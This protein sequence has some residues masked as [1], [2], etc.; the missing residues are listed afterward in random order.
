MIVV[1]LLT[2]FIVPMGLII[3]I[4]NYDNKSKTRDERIHDRLI[5]LREEREF[6][7]DLRNL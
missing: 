1:V 6:E 2:L 4:T 5:A 7:N 3:A